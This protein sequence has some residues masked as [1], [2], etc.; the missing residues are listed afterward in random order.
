M[1]CGQ[2][3]KKQ[4]KSA[5]TRATADL[6]INS[7]QV[8]QKLCGNSLQGVPGPLTEPVNSSAVDQARE[9]AQPLSELTAHRAEA[10]HHVQVALHLR[11]LTCVK[12]LMLTLV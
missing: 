2:C 1:P 8:C 11:Q 5:W 6:G 7:W 4:T 3:S 10:Q 9:L 12:Q